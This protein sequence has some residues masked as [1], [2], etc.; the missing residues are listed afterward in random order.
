MPT[1]QLQNMALHN[2]LINYVSSSHYTN[3]QQTCSNKQQEQT[4]SYTKKASLLIA[5]KNNFLALLLLLK[6]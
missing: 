6:H 5:N 1:Y 4:G 3:V 2:Y